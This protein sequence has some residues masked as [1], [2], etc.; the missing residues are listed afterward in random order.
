MPGADD[1][2]KEMVRRLA[3]LSDISREYELSQLAATHGVGFAAAVR[4]E[5]KE[6]IGKRS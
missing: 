4:R 6:K 3:M 2:V 1:K 5:E